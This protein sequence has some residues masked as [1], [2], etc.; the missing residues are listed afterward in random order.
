MRDVYTGNNN[1]VYFELFF[2]CSVLDFLCNLRFN[3]K[4]PW[5]NSDSILNF[6]LKYLV[7]KDLWI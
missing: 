1:N 5:L 7:I 6:E 2:K 3:Y 4:D